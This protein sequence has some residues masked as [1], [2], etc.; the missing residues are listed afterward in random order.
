MEEDN[1]EDSLWYSMLYNSNSI[2]N[3]ILKK[4]KIKYDLILPIILRNRNCVISDVLKFDNLILFKMIIKQYPERIFEIEIEELK[5]A[6][7]IIFYLK[8]NIYK[9]VNHINMSSDDKRKFDDLCNFLY[10]VRPKL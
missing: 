3:H 6:S 5:T 2:R 10:K 7:E 1:L 8:Y 9:L 4:Y